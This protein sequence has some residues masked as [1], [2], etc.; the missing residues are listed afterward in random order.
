MIKSDYHK[1]CTRD[2]PVDYTATCP[3]GKVLKLGRW[4]VIRD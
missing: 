4:V 3:S 2:K 1:E